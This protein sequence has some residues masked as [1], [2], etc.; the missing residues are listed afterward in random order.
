VQFA[1]VAIKKKDL[2]ANQGGA[3]VFL[4]YAMEAWVAVLMLVM[5]LAYIDQA[6]HYV[7]VFCQHALPEVLKFVKPVSA[8]FILLV[9]LW[10]AHSWWRKR[11]EVRE[12]TE[13]LTHIK[14][15]I[16]EKETAYHKEQFKYEE[17]KRNYL[18]SY[19]NTFRHFVTNSIRSRVESR[20]SR[21]LLKEELLPK[22]EQFAPQG[23]AACSAYLKGLEEAEYLKAKFKDIDKWE[24]FNFDE[25]LPKACDQK[26]SAID[27][28][29]KNSERDFRDQHLIW[30]IVLQHLQ[31]QT[32]IA[33][34]RTDAKRL[35]DALCVTDKDIKAEMKIGEECGEDATKLER[36]AWNHSK[37]ESEDKAKLMLAVELQNLQDLSIASI[38]KCAKILQASL[39]VDNDELKRELRQQ[40]LSKGSVS[41]WWQQDMKVLIQ[42]QRDHM[43]AEDTYLK[44]Q[45]KYE[46]EQ[47]Q[48]MDDRREAVKQCLET[49][50]KKRLQDCKEYHVTTLSQST[51]NQDVYQKGL[52]AAASLNRKQEEAN[53][54]EQEVIEKATKDIDTELCRIDRD[55]KE[56]ER[57]RKHRHLQLGVKLH[58]LHSRRFAS[59]RLVSRAKQLQAALC[60]SDAEVKAEVNKRKQEDG[61]KP[62]A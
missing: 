3:A 36:I 60:V 49:C 8:V 31:D 58:D 46:Q 54:C 4:Q 37:M 41:R 48:K 9:A 12:S 53:K 30:G 44:D 33:S 15:R 28:Q 56:S 55:R 27:D 50:M 61:T 45:A 18:E 57:N 17:E 32:S 10:C 13:L 38:G 7:G 51:S 29:K 25:Y 26:L 5:S 14:E 2:V 62:K 6:A 1:S 19:M 34:I 35:Q 21:S 47:R 11:T 16:K 22:E 42:Y 20:K 40:E 43:E 24:Q 52:Y 39:S 59:S 23:S